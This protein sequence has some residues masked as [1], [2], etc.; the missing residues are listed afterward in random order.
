VIREERND[1]LFC[2]QE[3]SPAQLLENLRYS[4]FGGLKLNLL[5][6]LITFMLGAKTLSFVWVLAN[7]ISV[8]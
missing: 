8:C 6:F 2:G 5:S 3:N 7:F 4:H 1:K